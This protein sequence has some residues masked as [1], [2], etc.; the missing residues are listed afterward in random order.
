MWRPHFNY[1]DE[2]NW[3]PREHPLYSAFHDARLGLGDWNY[4]RA[5]E[6]AALTD[7]QNV[8]SHSNVSEQK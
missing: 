7:G 5:L 4:R 3:P 1:R 2:Q 6:F 8:R